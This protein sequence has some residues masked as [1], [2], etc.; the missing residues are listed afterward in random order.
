[1]KN[2]KKNA[3]ASVLITLILVLSAATTFQAVKA[4]AT[5]V[6]TSSPALS[7]KEIWNFT[8][9]DTTAHATSLEWASP[10]VANGIAYVW[11]TETYIITGE[12]LD[13]FSNPIQHTLGAIYALNA[14]SGAKLWNFTTPG[15]VI[16]LNIVNGIA[17]YVQTTTL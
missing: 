13:P 6:A 16:S 15:T 14:S 17:M 1:M 9:A 4:A 7:S 3:F 8:A 5:P 2:L 11:N 12:P 10:V